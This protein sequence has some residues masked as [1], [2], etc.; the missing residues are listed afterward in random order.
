MSSI[1]CRLLLTINLLLAPFYAT[2]DR[3]DS[4]IRIGVL[5]FEGRDQALER[6]QPTAEYLATHIPGI[7]FQVI[8]LSH[9]EF[10]HAINQ[11]RLDFVLTNPAHFA[12]L[13][14]KY[15]ISRIATFIANPLNQ[16]QARFSAVLFT[17][18]DSPITRLEELR[19]KRLAAVSE[20]AF[21]GYQLARDLLLQQGIDTETDLDTQWFGFP[22][23]A[24]VQAVLAGKADAGTVR[25]GVLEAMANRGDLGL[26]LVRVLAPRNNDGYPL[27]HSMDMYPE[28][29]F[30][31]LHTT[32]STLSRQ[33]A[34]ALMS[35]DAG[36]KAARQSRGAG[37]TIPLSD[38]LV[39]SVL[40]RLEVPPYAPRQPSFAAMLDR[41]GHWLLIITLLLFST[42]AALLRLSRVNTH[43]RNAQGL[44]H[45]NQGELEEAARLRVRELDKTR[46]VLDDT[47][48]HK[49][50]V[51]RDV[52][53][54]CDALSALYELFLREDLQA[55]Q[56]MAAMVDAVRRQLDTEFGLLS[57]VRDDGFEIQCISPASAAATNLSTPLLAGEARKAIEAH[58][59]QQVRDLPQW[60]HYLACP[61][62]L[63]GELH[64]LLEFATR[65][66]LDTPDEGHNEQI[67]GSS[68][69]AL[70]LLNLVAQWIGHEIR[71]EE[72]N[73]T[74]QQRLQTLRE[75]FSAITPRER[76]V[77]ALLVKGQSNKE[78]ARSLNLSPKTVEMHRASLLRKTRAKS[79]T[80]LVQL[81]VS[82]K[83]LSQQSQPSVKNRK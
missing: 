4:N 37:W 45:K 80:E 19:G 48:E 56:R 49:A 28:W 79:S 82:S 20:G 11:G 58:H 39:H 16:P 68:E 53:S 33:V 50:N 62:Y 22:H 44:L 27:L 72:H 9:Q 10:E 31:R 74:E 78:I 65:D 8:P 15:G 32:S 23:A 40:Q 5:A 30:A 43:L 67:S 51:E 55:E 46:E 17:R 24:V 83:W 77:L 41:Y 61:V 13:T 70:N 1:I 71:R 3:L 42:L 54:A 75:R 73:N 52:H 81:S 6:W 7:R 21:G 25:S 2:A 38:S 26:H 59:I 18:A 12:H 69:L 35:M 57:R 29:P 66:A 63:E 76:D 36:S 60:K 34:L 47:R 64:C 14:V